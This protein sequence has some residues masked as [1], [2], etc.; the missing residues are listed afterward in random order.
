MKSKWLFGVLI[1][2]VVL[3]VA[4]VGFLAGYL[5]KGKPGGRSV[6]PTVGLALLIRGLPEER[7]KQ[8][9]REGVPVLSD[10]EL[11]RS[12]R[13][14]MRELRG[15]QR[16]IGQA[17]A[18]E[19]FDPE[20]LAA[21]LARYRQHFAANQAGN[22]QAL[23]DILARLTPEERRRFLETMGG[24]HGRREHAR[25]RRGQPAGSGPRR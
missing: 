18:A 10:G 6:D 12:I 17:L 24:N 25:P 1:V 7:R 9:A 23:V 8:L 20:M 19:P 14:S 4:A 2:S 3:N 21:A 16:H 15:T 5:G 13:V 11:R 22:H